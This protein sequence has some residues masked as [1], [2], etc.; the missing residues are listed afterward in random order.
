MSHNSLAVCGT[1][2]WLLG[3]C[4]VAEA[5]IDGGD[6]TGDGPSVWQYIVIALA[7]AFVFMTVLVC[8]QVARL[9]RRSE[10]LQLHMRPVTHITR[11]GARVYA[12]APILNQDELDLLPIVDYQHLSDTEQQSCSICLEHF[13]SM[14]KVR[15]LP[16]QHAFHPVCIDPWLTKHSAECPMCKRTCVTFRQNSVADHWHTVQTTLTPFA[17][18]SSSRNSFTPELSD[19]FSTATALE[20]SPWNSGPQQPAAVSEPAAI[21]TDPSL[22]TPD[23]TA[24]MIIPMPEQTPVLPES[25]SALAELSSVSATTVSMSPVPEPVSTLGLVPSSVVVSIPT[26]PDATFSCAEP[27]STTTGLAH[28]VTGPIPTNATTAEPNLSA[29]DSPALSSVSASASTGTPTHE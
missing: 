26:T 11:S 15:L 12:P 4:S 21:T 3:L 1:A 14:V 23:P 17:M 8:V 25:T 28:S 20:S 9:R 5:S 18:S 10:L 7:L 6:E 22:A 19:H 13:G 2:I 27:I 29:V 24:S 16:C